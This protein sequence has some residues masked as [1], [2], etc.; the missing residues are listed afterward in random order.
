MN[1][2]LTNFKN[3]EVVIRF[4]SEGQ[5]ITSTGVF[6]D[7]YEASDEEDLDKEFVAIQTETDYDRI[8][9]GDVRKIFLK[10]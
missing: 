9:L 2:N 8:P 4:M 6:T 7:C 3:K 5:L 10:E 1:R